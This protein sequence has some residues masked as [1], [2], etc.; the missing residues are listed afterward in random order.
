M[1]FHKKTLRKMDYVYKF[2]SEDYL[3]HWRQLT[4]FGAGFG[5]QVGYY[6]LV[7]VVTARNVGW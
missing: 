6:E 4:D 2:G 7:E 1:F 5:P 3:S